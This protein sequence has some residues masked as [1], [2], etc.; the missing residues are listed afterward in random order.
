[1]LSSFFH[2]CDLLEV[3]NLLSA[4]AISTTLYMYEKSIDS[5]NIVIIN[6]MIDLIEET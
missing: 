6:I 2:I 3:N 4:H 5:Y 1:M